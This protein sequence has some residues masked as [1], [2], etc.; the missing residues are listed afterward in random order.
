M[1]VSVGLSS[2]QSKDF[3]DLMNNPREEEDQS[4]HVGAGNRTTKKD[5]IM[6][7]YDFQPIRPF[8]SFDGSSP[9]LNLD[10]T[11]NLGGS[12]RACNSFDHKPNTCSP[13]RVTTTPFPI[14]LIACFSVLMV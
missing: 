2:P 3:I 7:S 8:G 14:V 11:P 5:S 6:T 1:D 4:S 12:S 9:S 10:S 13:I